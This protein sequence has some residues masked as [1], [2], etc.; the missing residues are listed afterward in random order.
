[1]SLLGS[2]GLVSWKGPKA[3]DSAPTFKEAEAMKESEVGWLTE[4]TQT[5]NTEAECVC[6]ACHLVPDCSLQPPDLSQ[7]TG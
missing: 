6:L 5:G 7:G 1:M 2:S 4:L 3:S